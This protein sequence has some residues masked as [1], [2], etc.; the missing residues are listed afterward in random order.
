M[1][2]NSQRSMNGDL[3]LGAVDHTIR[4]ANGEDRGGMVDQSNY[5]RHLLAGAGSNSGWA[6]TA[7]D[8]TGDFLIGDYLRG[9]VR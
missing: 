9:L 1:A 2:V 7:I 5:Y 6:G 3:R 4:L 8:L